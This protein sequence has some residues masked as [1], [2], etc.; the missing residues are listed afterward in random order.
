MVS[1]PQKSACTRLRGVSIRTQNSRGGLCW[2]LES[3]NRYM[4][5]GEAEGT[6]L[7]GG[8]FMRKATRNYLLD[9]LQGLLLLLQ[10]I[11]GFILWFVLSKG[12]AWG[13]GGGESAFIFA[14]HTWLGIHKWL[15]VVLLIVIIAHLILH[16]RW[17]VYMTKS[18]FRNPTISK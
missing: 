1:L 7:Y 5:T 13:G 14:R 8:D 16:W 15:A 10:S 12:I 17:V 18:Y 11:S 3:N 6:S 4:Y 9:A 2:G